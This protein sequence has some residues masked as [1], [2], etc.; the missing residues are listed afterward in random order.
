MECVAA[1]VALFNKDYFLLKGI[2]ENRYFEF[3]PKSDLEFNESLGPKISTKVILN[4]IIRHV[5]LKY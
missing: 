2:C 5:V 4:T 1:M 3:Q